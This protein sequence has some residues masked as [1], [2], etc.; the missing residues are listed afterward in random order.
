MNRKAKLTV[1]AA[2]LVVLVCLA[3]WAV[4]T[5]GILTV[6]FAAAPPPPITYGLGG[7]SANGTAS[8]P[9]SCTVTVSGGVPPYKM[10]PDPTATWPTGFTI[11]PVANNGGFTIAGTYAGPAAAALNF[12]F[13]VCD[14][15]QATC[16]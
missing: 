14:S 15:T 3:A 11:T 4:S 6:N 5:K 10:V 1:A 16:P 12:N 8:V 7:C 13:I 2:V 9:Y